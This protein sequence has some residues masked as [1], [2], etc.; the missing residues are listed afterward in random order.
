[1][2]KGNI[3]GKSHI[4]WHDNF[5]KKGTLQTIISEEYRVVFNNNS[6]KKKWIKQ[7]EY[8]L[9]WNSYSQILRKSYLHSTFML[10]WSRKWQEFFIFGP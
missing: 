4:L 3:S 2:K 9:T 1:M 7:E 5:K 10:D 6:K 8:Y